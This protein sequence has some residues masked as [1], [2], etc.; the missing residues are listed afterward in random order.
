M[1]GDQPNTPGNSRMAA[2]LRGGA[3]S[4]AVWTGRVLAYPVSF[5]YRVFANAVSCTVPFLL[6][7]LL[8]WLAL[9]LYVR[10]TDV[11]DSETFNL[12]AAIGLVGWI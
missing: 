7:A 3:A 6:V 11:S 12:I 8:A 10:V 9:E 5:G 1:A 4:L 2:L